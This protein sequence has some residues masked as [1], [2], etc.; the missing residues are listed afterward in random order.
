MSVINLNTSGFM[1]NID[2]YMTF[3]SDLIKR[4]LKKKKAKRKIMKPRR[5]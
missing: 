4:S 3:L 5:R 1:T 2:L